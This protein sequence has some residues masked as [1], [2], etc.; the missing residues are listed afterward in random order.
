MPHVAVRDKIK[1]RAP[2]SEPQQGDRVPFVIIHGQG[3]MY[4]KAEDP[5]WVT[6][7]NL[8]IDYMYYFTNQ[9]KKPVADLLEPLISEDLVF[10]KKFLSETKQA[11]IKVTASVELDA[12]KAFLRRFALKV[13]SV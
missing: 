8:K 13:S 3:K 12:R 7:K 10:D 11:E 4:E 1:R 2:G 9:F 5:A 6:E